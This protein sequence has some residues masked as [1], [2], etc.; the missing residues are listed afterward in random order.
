MAQLVQPPHSESEDSMAPVRSFFGAL[1]C[2]FAV[3]G[4][5][6]SVEPSDVDEESVP[7]V[8][9]D[10][11]VGVDGLPIWTKIFRATSSVPGGYT[12]YAVTSDRYNAAYNLRRSSAGLELT[13]YDGYGN[14]VF[15]K[16]VDPPAEEVLT[17]GGGRVAAAG[18]I[19][20]GPR[21][22]GGVVTVFGS[23]SGAKLYYR[24][25]SSDIGASISGAALDDAGNLIVAGFALG[26]S[27]QVDGSDM[28]NRDADGHD[29]FVIKYDRSGTILWAH[30]YGGPGDQD[31]HDVAVD[32]S[33]SIY[34]TGEYQGTMNIDGATVTGTD[35]TDR[36]QRDAFLFKLT[37]DGRRVWVK[38]FGGEGRQSG[39]R[40]AANRSGQI[41]LQGDF[42]GTINLGGGTLVSRAVT[43]RP[44]YAPRDVYMAAFGPDGTHVHSHAITSPGSVGPQ[45]VGIDEAGNT[46]VGGVYLGDARVDGQ[47]L[48]GRPAGQTRGFAVRYTAN[49]TLAWANAYGEG[50][51]GNTSVNA[52]SMTPS[53]RILVV[54]HFTGALRL[55]KTTFQS[56]LTAPPSVFFARLRP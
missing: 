38:T 45:G 29:A 53:G 7:G 40:L 50:D 15:R 28:T 24:I 47:D 19:G 3:I 2:T 56:S 52:L 35:S 39:V 14:F 11:V 43:G 27:N 31:A 5:G 23:G 16:L 20:L 49:G 32:A 25:V 33:G 30:R 41:A 36:E 21:H 22:I 51:E 34:V 4:C 46:S 9:E 17:A 42:A 26:R 6:G 48:P 10:E 54:G 44:G 12:S 37:S 55:G 13:K 8:S 1:L 18:T